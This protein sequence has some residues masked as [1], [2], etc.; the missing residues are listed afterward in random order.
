MR[1][2]SLAV[3][4]S[5][6]ENKRGPTRRFAIEACSPGDPIELRSEPKNPADPYAV[7]VFDAAGVQM[8]YLTAERAPWIGGM[9]LDGR[10]I[11]AVFQHS[12]SWGAVIRVA[13]DGE[14]PLL[15]GLSTAE[16]RAPEEPDFYPDEIYPDD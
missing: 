5:Q 15:E 7:A 3:V 12:T 9:I 10:E 2:L 11:A 14:V 16:R 1:A 8:G 4:G 13:F 6:Y